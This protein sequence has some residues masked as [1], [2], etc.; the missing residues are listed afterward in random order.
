MPALGLASLVAILVVLN[1]VYIRAVAVRPL[2]P[3]VIAAAQ[4]AAAGTPAG[5]IIIANPRVIMEALAFP[6][7]R[8]HEDSLHHKPWPD[9]AAKFDAMPADEVWIIS[10]AA[11]LSPR[12]RSNRCA[13]P[14]AR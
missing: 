11:L 6:T 8:R 5:R 4:P 12:S 2:E 3:A 9:H 1:T 10:C 13:P 7:G 14:A